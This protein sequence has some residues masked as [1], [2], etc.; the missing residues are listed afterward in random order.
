MNKMLFIYNGFYFDQIRFGI[1]EIELFFTSLNETNIK[2]IM[3][4]N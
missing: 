3:I 4:L 2:L 1:N